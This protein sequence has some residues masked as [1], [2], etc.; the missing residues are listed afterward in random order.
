MSKKQMTKAELLGKL[1][2]LGEITE[3]QRKDVT[4]SLVGHSRIINM[5]LGY[6]SCGRCGAHLGDTLIG[7]DD[8]KENVIIGHHCKTC[9][10][11]AKTLTWR[12]TL[13]TPDPF[14]PPTPE[15]LKMQ[16]TL[17]KR[18]QERERADDNI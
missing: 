7:A 18:R 15:Q 12:D 6:M 9:L 1:D 16:A 14:P 2:A 17:E 3:Q 11:N 13:Y 8:A 10:E 4:C 5:C